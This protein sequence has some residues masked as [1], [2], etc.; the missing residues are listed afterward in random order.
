MSVG[1]LRAMYAQVLGKQGVGS[2]RRASHGSAGQPNMDYMMSGRSG[3]PGTGDREG[4]SDD[5]GSGS[6]LKWVSEAIS[7]SLSEAPSSF[8]PVRLMSKT[9]LFYSRMQVAL[10]RWVC[11]PAY[12]TYP[13]DPFGRPLGD[14][15]YKMTNPAPVCSTIAALSTSFTPCEPD[16]VP[17]R[18]LLS[19]S[20]E[21]QSKY[22]SSND[23]L[24]N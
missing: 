5:R 8:A 6:I 18:G 12:K 1:L 4:R 7:Q 15:T 13:C 17:R 21:P 22:G 16:A 14:P 20:L 23:R 2:G 11:L 9:S 24:L 3:P 19:S 10:P